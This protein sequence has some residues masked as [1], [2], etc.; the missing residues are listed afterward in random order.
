VI[1]GLTGSVGSGKSTLAQFLR[2]WRFQV[3][4]VDRVAASAAKQAGLDPSE[5][6]RRVL[7]GDRALEAQLAVFVK[8]HVSAWLA[9]AKPPVI[10]DSALLF[11]QGLDALCTVTICLTCPREE[12]KARVEK[13]T[14]V[15]ATHFDAIERAQWAEAGKASKATYVIDGDRE[16]DLVSAEVVRLLGV[17]A[18]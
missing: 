9:S 12:R 6:L 1:L 5:A 11:E 7:T 4:D 16:L 8:E 18:P 2:T 14:T 3:L 10:I 17:K 15:S 13:R